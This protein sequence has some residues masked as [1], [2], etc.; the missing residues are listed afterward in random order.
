MCGLTNQGKRRLE[1]VRLSAELGTERSSWLE[2]LG[3]L[4]MCRLEE[5]FEKLRSGYEA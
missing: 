5:F 1:A 2:L 3:V 4:V